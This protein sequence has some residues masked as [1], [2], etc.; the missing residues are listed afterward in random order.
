MQNTARPAMIL[1]AGEQAA[2]NLLPVRHYAP[3]AVIILHTSLANSLRAAQ[4]LKLRLGGR[5]TRLEPVDA[6]DPG[7]ATATISNLL[8]EYPQAIVNVTG[9]TKP[10]SMAALA[11]ARTNGG[12]PIYV[13]SQGATTA[14]DV[15]AFDQTGSP[16]VADSFVLTDVISLQDYLTIYF[17]TAFTCTDF[18]HGE[19]E[20]FERAL[21]PIIESAVDEVAVGW[22]HNSGAVDVD[23]VLRCNNQIGIIEAKTGKKAGTTDGIKQL[24]VA[25]GQRFFGTYTQRFMV[26]DRELGERTNVR[27]LADA[28]GIHVVQLPSFQGGTIVADEQREF[29]SR[30]VEKLGQPVK[31]PGD[32]AARYGASSRSS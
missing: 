23:F 31:A 18:G 10:M 16:V 3:E 6:Y 1:L 30:L 24:A 22:K 28:L 11:A 13:R 21:Y 8:Q 2:P 20:A 4:N 27:S 15:Y 5:P 26:I 7:E 25:G 17:G 14:I 29:V 9:G 12:Q 19:G 32:R